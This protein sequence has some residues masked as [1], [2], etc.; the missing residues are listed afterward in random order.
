M[1]EQTLSPGAA[2]PAPTARLRLAG[3]GRPRRLDW[4]DRSY[5]V[6][7][8]P[9]PLEDA[10]GSCVTHPLPAHGWRFQGTALDDG[11]ARVFDLLWCDDGWVVL[12]TYR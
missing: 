4:G 9:T 11:D 12:K 7:D 2:S 10:V 5:L 8:L 1:R 6:T 3:D